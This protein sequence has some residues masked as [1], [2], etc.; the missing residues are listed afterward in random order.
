MHKITIKGMEQ[1][2]EKRGEGGI[3][4]KEEKEG[5]GETKK[6]CISALS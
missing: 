3:R 4:K 2:G 1:S 5:E 6:P